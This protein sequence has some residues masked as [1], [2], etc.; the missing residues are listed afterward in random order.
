MIS[1]LFNQATA[2]RSQG[3]KIGQLSY[4]VRR[5]RRLTGS[6]LGFAG[7]RRALACEAS[8]SKQLQGGPKPVVVPSILSS[9]PTKQAG[10]S[11]AE[12]KASNL[13]RMLAR[14]PSYESYWER[15]SIIL[16]LCWWTPCKVQR[17]SPAQ[18]KT[19]RIAHTGQLAKKLGQLSEP[20]KEERTG[21][22]FQANLLSN[23]LLGDSLP[24]WFG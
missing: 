24:E 22:R 12:R 21:V 13:V 3:S 7:V 17:A 11:L 23:N 2:R 8:I 19:C 10:R 1:Y 4:K 16:A 18:N 5:A 9:G 6:K 20:G 14:N 15:V